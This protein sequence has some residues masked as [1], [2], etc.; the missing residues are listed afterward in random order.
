VLVDAAFTY[1][2]NHFTETPATD[3]YNITDLTQTGGL[4]GQRG[5]FIAQGIASWN[6]MNLIPEASAAM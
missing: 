2:W 1:S 4:A 6:R 3:V 5:A